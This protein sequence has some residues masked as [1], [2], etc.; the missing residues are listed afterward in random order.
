MPIRLMRALP[1]GPLRTAR[2]A[3][4][5]APFP[6]L[7][8][9]RQTPE[10]KKPCKRAQLKKCSARRTPGARLKQGCGQEGRAAAGKL[11]HSCFCRNGLLADSCNCDL[12]HTLFAPCKGFY[13]SSSLI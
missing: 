2:E 7:S 9:C 8:A 11:Q 3:L 10:S 5:S 4:R 6:A 13:L 12:T 1:D